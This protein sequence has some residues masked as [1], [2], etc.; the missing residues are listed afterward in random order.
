M[1]IFFTPLKY[2]TCY[3]LPEDEKVRVILQASEHSRIL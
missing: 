3:L 2:P 1:N